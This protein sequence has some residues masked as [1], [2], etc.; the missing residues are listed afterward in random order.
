M[1]DLNQPDLDEL[2]RRLGAA[3]AGTRPRRGFED[4]LWTR[5]RP[6]RPWWRPAA[7]NPWPA[8]G[9]VAA[10]LLIGLAAVLVPHA[11]LLRSGTGGHPSATSAANQPAGPTQQAESARGERLAQTAPGAFGRVPAPTLASPRFSSL[12]KTADSQVL[13]P[14]PVVSAQLPTVPASLPVYR[15]VQPSA[16]DRERFAAS[17]GAHSSGSG[18]YQGT[19]FSLAFGPSAGGREPTFQLTVDPTSPTG[20]A[21]TAA[22]AQ[23]LAGDFLDSHH[24]RPSWPAQLSV[25]MQGSAAVVRYQRQFDVPGL[26]G[27]GQWDEAGSPAGLEVVVGPDRRVTLVTGPMP[28]ALQ[29]SNY[30]ARTPEQA[31][32]DAAAPTGAVPRGAAQTAPVALDRVQLVYLAVGDGDHG[33]F[34]P[35]YLFTGSAGAGGAAAGS[36]VLVPALDASQLK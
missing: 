21:P 10:V 34:V 12:P 14:A 20:Q 5:L 7:A 11:N 31:A 32:R 28:L 25:E 18:T 30:R 9:A 16:A 33:Y 35:A 26:G 1:D 6:G 15:F 17:L 27:L 36:Q 29:S 19:D 8:L 3:F 24:L 23:R 22:E 13:G 2:E 4:E